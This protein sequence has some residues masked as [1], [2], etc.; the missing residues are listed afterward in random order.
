MKRLVLSGIGLAVLAAAAWYGYGYMVHGRFIEATDDAYVR[1]DMAPVAARIAGYVEA[2][3][4]AE[5]QQVKA[6]DV[7]V[8]IEGGDFDTKVAQA[9]A[10]IA[11]KQ[12]AIDA[13]A[14]RLELEAQLI[15]AAEG[16]VAAA[17]ADVAQ[18]AA[19]LKRA[20]EL[21]DNG[22][23]TQARLDA[24]IAAAAKAQAAL[25]SALAAL[26][27]EK[28]QVSV[29][30]TQRAQAV[31]DKAQAEA[32]ARQAALDKEHTTLRAP[33]DGVVA[34]R[35]AEPGQYVRAGQQLMTIV[36]LPNVYV[37][38]NFKETQAGE[39][40]RGQKVTVTV[41]AFPDKSFA[42][43]ID[44][45]APATGS[46]FA[47]IPPENATGNFTKIVQRLPVKILLQADENLTLLRPGMSVTAEIDVRDEG[48]G[49]AAR[50]GALPR[51]GATETAA[52]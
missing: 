34:N 3:P 25:E 20:R 8:T 11:A 30:E 16:R 46:E 41:D 27:A 23:G 9:E 18:T 22:T 4:A 37:V 17:R 38:A 29:L 12:A 51:T 13:V 33:F 1:A 26:A 19:D 49:E 40:R 6:G 42:G 47:L 21:K 15:G 50:L 14:A 7:L 43:T 35:A 2:V 31:A 32:A 52:Q 45:F 24:A 36:P 39:M 10:Q 48:L 28:E 44:S 5:N